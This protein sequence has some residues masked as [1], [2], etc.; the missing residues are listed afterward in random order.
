MSQT[1]FPCPARACYF[2][3]YPPMWYLQ[4]RCRQRQLLLSPDPAPRGARASRRGESAGSFSSHLGCSALRYGD[5]RVES[6]GSLITLG[7]DVHNTSLTT[8]AWT[9]QR[10]SSLKCAAL[11]SGVFPKLSF[12]LEVLQS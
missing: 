7:V 11:N 1:P 9:L 3:V 10:I 8:F 2:L 4:P 6:L 12:A 5:W